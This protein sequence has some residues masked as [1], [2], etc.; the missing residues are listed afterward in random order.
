[1]AGDAGKWTWGELSWTENVAA[2]GKACGDIG[3][4]AGRRSIDRCADPVFITVRM[5]DVK[6][7][8][9]IEE[10]AID[11]NLIGFRE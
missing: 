5:G 1:M 9:N 4:A 8:F 7:F 3:N 6:P 2:T 10:D 11:L